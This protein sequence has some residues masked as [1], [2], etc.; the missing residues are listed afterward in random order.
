MDTVQCNVHCSVDSQHKLRVS[1]E[2]GGG[3]PHWAETLIVALAP[4]QDCLSLRVL[5]EAIEGP[6]KTKK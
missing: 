5:P 2:L 4:S 3:Q 6:P 1:P